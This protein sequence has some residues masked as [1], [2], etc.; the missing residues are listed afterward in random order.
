MSNKRATVLSLGAGVQSSALLL[1]AER[2]IV[3]RPDFAVFADTGAEPKQVYR[4]LD[5][6][7]TKVTIPIHRTMWRNLYDDTIANWNNF[8]MIP[9]FIDRDGKKGLGKR[10]CTNKYKI[11]QIYRE[12][13]KQLGY[14]PRKH[15]KHKVTMQMGISV[16]EAS[17]M[18]PSRI[19]WVTNSFPLIDLGL[20]RADCKKFVVGVLGKAPPRSA[21]TFCPYRSNEEWI[22]MKK[23]DPASWAQAIEVD[24]AIRNAKEKNGTM[25]LHRSCQ[26]LS[27]ADLTDKQPAL[28]DEEC[29]GICGV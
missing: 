2:G 13:R 7:E 17:R 24:E 26:P 25:Y 6:I 10:Q 9:A 21:C 23:T 14:A 12:V 19:K 27:G 4:W 28:W 18:K 5:Y 1:M 29:A 20:S 3:P 16:D 8:L 15:T 11:E 22:N